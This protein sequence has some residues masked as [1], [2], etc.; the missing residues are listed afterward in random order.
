MEPL[1]VKHIVERAAACFPQTQIV[2]RGA[3]DTR[4]VYTYAAFY[5]RLQRAAH[6]LDRLGVA[7]GETVGVLGWNTHRHLEVDYA[8]IC[9]GSI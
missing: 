3:G 8:A 7:R 9:K 4:F 1:L 5:A 6:V 2:A